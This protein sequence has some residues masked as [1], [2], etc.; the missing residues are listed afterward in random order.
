LTFTNINVK[1][2]QKI[3][4]LSQFGRGVYFVRRRVVFL[5]VVT[6]F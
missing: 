1:I 5:A 4:E 2:K 6:S 3:P